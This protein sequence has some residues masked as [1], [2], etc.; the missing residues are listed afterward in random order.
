MELADEGSLMRASKLMDAYD[1][2]PS[3]NLR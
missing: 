1:D 2:Y 3:N